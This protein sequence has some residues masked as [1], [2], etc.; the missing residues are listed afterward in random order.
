MKTD[1]QHAVLSR[2]GMILL[3]HQCACSCESKQHN[4]QVRAHDAEDQ[5]DEPSVGADHQHRVQQIGE[6]DRVDGNDDAEVHAPQS[7]IFA[8]V[9]TQL[10][11]GRVQRDELGPSTINSIG[12]R[13]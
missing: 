13:C 11:D 6:D 5:I 10:D 3:I 2:N 7:G 12:R 8:H 1:V 9:R 4:Q